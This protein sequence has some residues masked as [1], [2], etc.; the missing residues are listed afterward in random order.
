MSQEPRRSSRPSS[1]IKREELE[2]K[3]SKRK[4]ESE[5][6][7][8]YARS[9]ALETL[10]RQELEL[11]E[12]EA[13]RLSELVDRLYDESDPDKT[14]NPDKS[15]EWDSDDCTTSPSFVT[16]DTSEV[17]PTVQEI[18]ED[19]LNS[20]VTQQGGDEEVV[21]SEEAVK[22]N[23]RNTSTDNNFLASS[24]VV[25][26]RPVVFHWPPRFPSQEPEDY[27]LFYP[28]V[29]PRLPEEL[30]VE[31]E[32]FEEVEQEQAGTMDPTVYAAK[33]RVIK[34][35][36]KKVHDIKKSFVANDV[37]SMDIQNYES[38][39]KEIR[40]KLHSY[41]DA[42][43]DLIVDLDENNEEDKVNIDSLEAQQAQL[44]EE[45]KTNEKEVKE[46]VKSLLD[47][48]PLT[49][50]EQENIDLQRKKLQLVEKKEE[51]EKILKAKKAEITMKD[52][53]SKVASL[54]DSVKEVKAAKDLSD[55]EIKHL[56]PET[57]K[58][59]TKVEELVASR[60]KFNIELF[61]LNTAFK[62]KLVKEYKDKH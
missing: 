19:I 18:I 13:T 8:L 3:L 52:L 32:V 45:V 11:F 14:S 58:W 49:K 7:V 17:S 56:L 46:K 22:V 10:R 2:G 25:R 38:R 40:D 35:A 31:E 9:K 28:P 15:L 26:E 53:S 12:E 59:E 57:K 39:L 29:Q 16:I 5:I 41:D 48:Q 21:P 51:D 37:T 36:A 30:E 50:A 33:H 20:S 47:A 6:K 27:N 44:L 55:Q 23:R 42:V 1:V 60:V 24:P 54:M 61:G 43:A 62:E 4:A 34:L